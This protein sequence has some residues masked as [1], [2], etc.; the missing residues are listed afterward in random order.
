MEKR[1]QIT[2]Y[3]SEEI[4]GHTKN[5]GG[6]LEYDYT[7]VPVCAFV[8]FSQ[9]KFSISGGDT[10]MSYT[11]IFLAL[12]LPKSLRITEAPKDQEDLHAGG[13]EMV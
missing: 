6:V 7:V 5:A 2:T 8:R 10:E 11:E 3:G 4:L 12:S 13:E 9:V 1:K